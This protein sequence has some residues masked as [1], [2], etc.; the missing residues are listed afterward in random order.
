MKLT[1]EQ[2]EAKIGREKIKNL[3]AKWPLLN[4]ATRT[5]IMVIVEKQPPKRQWGF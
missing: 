4:E 5:Q 3:T 1:L 2:K